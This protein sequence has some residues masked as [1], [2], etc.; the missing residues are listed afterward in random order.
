MN[1]SDRAIKDANQ[2]ETNETRSSE[3][4]AFLYQGLFTGIVR[5]QAGREH[6]PDADTF[7]RRTKRALEEVERDAKLAGYDGDHIKQSHLAVA[8][9]LDSVVLHSAEPGRA[10]WVRQSLAEELF[11]IANAGEVF[12][13]K[14]DD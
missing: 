13:E 8:A 5:L 1:G 10:E 14:L 2:N 3:N 7:R 9:F 11:G 12:F 6:M 4:L